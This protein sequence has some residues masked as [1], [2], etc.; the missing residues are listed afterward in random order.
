MNRL[1]LLI[2]L[3]I[4]ASILSECERE[5]RVNIPDYQFL[6]T[7][8]DLGV[9]T[10][11]SGHI[12]YREA[13]AVTQLL[14]PNKSLRNL[15]GIEAFVNLLNLNCTNNF[16]EKINI[17]N[18]TALTELY[19]GGNMLTSLDV[20]NNPALEIIVCGGNEI[21]ELDFSNNP[22]LQILNASWS[23]ELTNMNVSKN[24]R[25]IKLWCFISQLTS[26]DV[27]NALDLEFLNCG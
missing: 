11:G 13:E 22:E 7:L 5:D 20:S 16:L 9:D 14:M 4:L 23:Y 10:D 2:P 8:I 26:L 6:K 12:S 21:T 19:L 27:S 24:T 17:A 25:L 15:D 18:N 1:R 3:V